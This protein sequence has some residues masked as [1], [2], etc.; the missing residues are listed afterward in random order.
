MEH[1][2]LLGRVDPVA[3]EHRL[4]LFAQPARA[5]QSDEQTDRLVRDAVLRVIEVQAGGLHGE[6]LAARRIVGEQRPEGHVAHLLV[7]RR[8]RP[9]R[10]ERR[11]R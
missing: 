1:G 8:K 7:M 10:R 4:D 5:G 2:A 9:P 3:A 11:Q 6:A